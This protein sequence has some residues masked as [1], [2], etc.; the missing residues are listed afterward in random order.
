M[1][2]DT[3][4]LGLSSDWVEHFT[5][6]FQQIHD[7]KRAPELTIFALGALTHRDVWEGNTFRNAAH[8]DDELDRAEA[9]RLRIFH[10]EYHV[11]AEEKITSTVRPVATGSPSNIQYLSD[12]LGIFEPYWLG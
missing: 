11:Q 12:H 4:S 8:D 10:I 3:L 7:S 6:S 1:S 2:P 5:D 9:L